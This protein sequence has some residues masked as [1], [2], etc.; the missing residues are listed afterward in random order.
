MQ[1]DVL[2]RPSIVKNTST[3]ASSGPRRKGRPPAGSLGRGGGP[4][5][6]KANATSMDARV[7]PGRQDEQLS[8]TGGEGS[9]TKTSELWF[10]DLIAITLLMA[11]RL[12]I[13][14][15][16]FQL[17]ARFRPQQPTVC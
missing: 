6:N 1:N 13:T 9:T 8:T 2:D 10:P 14:I 15:W 12:V 11:L 17:C 7:P 5:P 3:V 4:E 16:P